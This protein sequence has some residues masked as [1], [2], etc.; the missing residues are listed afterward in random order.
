MQRFKHKDLESVLGHV[1]TQHTK[2]RPWALTLAHLVCRY[3]DLLPKCGDDGGI[4]SSGPEQQRQST[5]THRA[6]A[7]TVIYK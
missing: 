1:V 2:I 3:Q 7:W 4:R 6:D 5:H